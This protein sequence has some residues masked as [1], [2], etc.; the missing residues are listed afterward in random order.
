MASIGILWVLQVT[1][2]GRFCDLILSKASVT[3]IHVEST[4][5]SLQ[6]PFL[7]PR[8]Y[9]KQLIISELNNASLLFNRKSSAFVGQIRE[10]KIER[11]DG[12]RTKSY[13]LH[14]WRG[15]SSLYNKGH[16]G[17]VNRAHSYL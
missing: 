17:V 4:L 16:Y 2:V 5:S 1:F 14:R 8:E 6:S 15:I 7:F 9:F 3:K 10:T 13:Q 11:A 12:L